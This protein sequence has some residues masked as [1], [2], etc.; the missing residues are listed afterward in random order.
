MKRA[1]SLN[2]LNVGL[3]ESQEAA[4]VSVESLLS[5]LLSYLIFTKAAFILWSVFDHLFW[6]IKI[7]Y[8]EIIWFKMFSIWYILKWNL[9]IWWQRWIVS[10]I[11]P[12]FSVTW[13]FRYHSDMLIWSLINISYHYHCW[14]QL[15]IFLV[16]T[17]IYFFQDSLI[18]YFTVFNLA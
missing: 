12:V 2:V 13:S 14:K 6:Y 17:E 11:T 1:N 5:N 16:E 10:I 3:K 9:F 4:M 8:C 7:L 18:K 15:Y